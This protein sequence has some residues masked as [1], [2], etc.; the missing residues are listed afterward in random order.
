M[1]RLACLLCALFAS[2]LLAGCDPA[3][4]AG[5]AVD[6]DCERGERC[7]DGTCAPGR[8]AGEVDGGRDA[9]EDAGPERDAGP[10]RGSGCSADLRD[11]L[12]A[13]GGVLRTCPA[14]RGC[15]DGDCVPACE[16]AAASRGTVGCEFAVPTPP[17]YPPAL[18]PCHA[19]FVANLWPSSAQLTVTRGGT[20]YDVSRFGRLADDARPADEWLPVPADG[21]PAGEVAVLFLS[22][23]PDAVMPENGVDLSCPVTPAIDA[24]TT[25]A[26]DVTDA[27][28]IEAD[29]PVRAYDILPYG[30]ARSHFP[31]AQLLL[32]ANAW[33]EEYVVIGPPPGTH[34]TPGP[35]WFQIAAERDGTTIQVRPSVDLAA[36]GALP[37]IAAGTTGSVTLDAGQYLQWEVGTRDPSGTVI[38]ADAPVAVLA[39]NRFLR[40]QPS[41]APGGDSAHQQILPVDAL[42]SE[43]VAAPHDTRRADLAPEEIRYRIVGAFDGTTLTF[44]PPLPGA[45]SAI[46]RGETVEVSSPNAFVVR[47]QDRMHPF[48][49]AQMMT[50][51]NVEGGSRPGAVAPGY[52][53]WLGDEE[54]VVAFPPGQFLDAYVFFTDP[55]YPT[56]S[57]TVV[58]VA[59]DG[60]F[61][62]V[63]VDCLGP[64]SGWQP[65]G[66]DGRFEVTS[67]DLIRA[68]APVGGCTNGRRAAVSDAPFGLTVWGLD[69]Y[70]SYAYPAGGNAR[71]LAELPPLL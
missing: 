50:T 38:S 71:Q 65:A 56:T 48:A 21:V 40:L 13:V 11:V 27:F 5:C 67:V 34:T 9:G 61:Q 51:A 6:G 18:P 69:S 30:G 32:P 64:L 63:E 36:S 37:A 41:P 20:S 12:D 62:D 2:L 53:P 44:D 42:A 14:D 25:I 43:Y 46:G 7:V 28:R 10:P 23:D 31:S 4:M 19:V 52:G 1:S 39:G 35:L 22:S 60:A 70:S 17:S 47:S 33:G 24:A 8:D 49:M 45:P 66:T 3:P 59:V 57:L 26:T 68:G 55:A 15:L 16:A 58:R 29:V 54:F